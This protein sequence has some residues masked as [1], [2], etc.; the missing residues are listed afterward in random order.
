MAVVSSFPNHRNL[1]K[2]GLA[3]SCR[4]IYFSTWD[5]LLHHTGRIY[6]HTVGIGVS[7]SRRSFPVWK[8]L[9]HWPRLQ[10]ALFPCCGV[11][12]GSAPRHPTESVHPTHLGRGWV[13]SGR[14]CPSV[15]VLQGAWTTVWDL[16]THFQM[17]LVR[18]DGSPCN[19]LES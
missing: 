10:P 2:T 15:Q 13:I 6:F 19:C 8:E 18:S 12:A 5:F 7:R 9:K 4:F 16:H 17:S 3:I 14:C 1:F 11:R